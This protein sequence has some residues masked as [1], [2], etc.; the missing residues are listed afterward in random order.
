MVLGLEIDAG[1][2]WLARTGKHFCYEIR[3]CIGEMFGE[4][5]ELGD[6]DWNCNIEGKEASKNNSGIT[7]DMSGKY[8]SVETGFILY[9]DRIWIH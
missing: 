3:A 6:F 8:F 9:K 4:T 5:V 7:T 2:R 1:K